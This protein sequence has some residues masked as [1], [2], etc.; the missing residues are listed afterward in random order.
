[1]NTFYVYLGGSHKDNSNWMRDFEKASINLQAKYNG[2]S[3]KGV[4]PFDRNIDET[5][6]KAIVKRDLKILQDSRLTHV[7]LKSQSQGAMLSTGTASECIIASYLAKPII[8]IGEPEVNKLHTRNGTVSSSWYHPF[9]EYF[10]NVIV[11]DINEAIEW[12]CLDI[13]SPNKRTNLQYHLQEISANF[14]FNDD[15][16]NPFN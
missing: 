9:V 11:K 7:I 1:M 13:I 10:A 4:N 15:D 16:N 8:V 6:N 2:I 5:D 12:I 3:I 14:Q